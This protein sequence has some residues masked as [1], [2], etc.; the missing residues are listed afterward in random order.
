MKH[1]D[2]FTIQEIADMMRVHHTTIRNAIKVGH[3]NAFRIG[4]GKRASWRI[5]RSELQRLTESNMED[6]IE[7]IIKERSQ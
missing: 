5:P 1:N 7:K 4:M 2:F 3:I 6:V